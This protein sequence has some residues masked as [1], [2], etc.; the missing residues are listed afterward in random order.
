MQ[1]LWLWF[2]ERLHLEPVR[3]VVLDNLRKPVPPHVNWLFTLGAA[4][5]L[6]LSVTSLYL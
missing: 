3:Q 4:L 2:D 1:R 5:L 6:L